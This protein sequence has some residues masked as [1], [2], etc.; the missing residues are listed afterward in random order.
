VGQAAH[1]LANP[2]LSDVCRTPW[3][4][5]E[6][7]EG[8]NADLLDQLVDV[9]G[10]RSA[11]PMMLLTAP[12]AG[13]GKTHLLGRVAAAA[14]DQAVIVPVAFRSGDPLTLATLSR[15]GI[16][17]LAESMAAGDSLGWSR[18][19]EVSAHVVA[20]LLRRMIESGQLPCANAEQAV[21]TLSRG[22]QEVFEPAGRAAR[23]GT[24]ITQNRD[25]LRGPLAM[26]A[27]GEIPLRAE[28][29]DAWVAALLEQS[30]QGGLAGVAEMEE[31]T[32]A[33]NDTGVPAWLRLMSLW[34]PVVLLVDHLDG[35]YR[36]PEAGVR[37][38]SMLMELV[39]SHRLNVLLSLNQDVWQ[40]TFGHHLPSALEDRLT[41]SQVLLRGLTEADAAELLRLRL[42]QT[43]LSPEQRDEFTRFVSVNRHFLGRPIGSVSA[44]AFLRHCARQWEIFQ[45]SPPAS[46]EMPDSPPALPDF[47]G[48]V[49]VDV[50]PSLEKEPGGEIPLMTETLRLAA[51]DAAPVPL[52]VLFD[53]QTASDVLT[54]AESLTEP[55]AALPQDENFIDPAPPEILDEP[56]APAN[57]NG[58][59]PA[60][61]AGDENRLEDWEISTTPTEEKPVAPT[62]D[63]FVKLREM[64]A[65]LRQPGQVATALAAEGQNFTPPAPAPAPT[66]STVIAP[67]TPFRVPEGGLPMAP[68]PPSLASPF[69]VAANTAA[70]TGLAQIKAKAPANPADLLQGRFQA[71][72]LQLQAE[73]LTQPL[74]FSRLADLIRLAGRRFPLVRYSEH[75]LPGLTGRFALY[76][77]LQ[78]IEILFGLAPFSD[79]AYWRTLSG[80]AAGRVTDLASQ[81]ERDGGTATKLKIVGFKTEREQLSWQNLTNSQILPEPIRQI[82]DVVHLDTEGLASL[83]AM[84]RI[85]KESE[86]GVLQAE[87]AKV[88]GVLA[89]ELDFFWKRITRLA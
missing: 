48:G 45:S 14:S 29:L 32:T 1:L 81:A 62:T 38:A 73:A 80:F 78:G 72:R 76:W 26:A 71:L 28:S 39:E 56:L 20:L 59:H 68:P 79:A 23:I 82:T 13:Y 43:D 25:N 74:D 11:G 42:E 66:N 84:Q 53:D 83:Y 18:L 12:R 31:L 60:L 49:E 27:A 22:G 89:R 54:M 57:A 21:E 24:W 30:I 52:P 64:L 16:E 41:A 46:G 34:R 44:R 6:S 85:I 70:T 37:I 19:R 8:L 36:N 58:Q 50:L 88:I 61:P 65:R 33:D 47:S 5:N 15:R 77:S 40:A 87:P 2:F 3:Q 35:F 69:Q 17:S 4:V 63:A 9:V 67:E 51:D 7:V 55:R 75:E 86:S 10:G